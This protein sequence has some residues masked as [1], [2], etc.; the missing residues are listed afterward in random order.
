LVR[1]WLAATKQDP[2]VRIQVDIDP[3]SFL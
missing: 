1:D 2:A 3:Q